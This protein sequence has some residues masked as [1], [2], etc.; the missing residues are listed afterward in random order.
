MPR[1][2][3]RSEAVLRLEGPGMG[4]RA[5]GLNDAAISGTV[6]QSMK[7]RVVWPVPP[8]MEALGGVNWDGRI[9][10]VWGSWYAQ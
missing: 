1:V 5:K 4:E 6:W 7:V 10:G 9:A 2:L 3:V 8:E